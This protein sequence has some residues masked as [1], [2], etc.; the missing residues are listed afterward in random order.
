MSSSGPCR[1]PS[2]LSERKRS[3]RAGARSLGHQS[4]EGLGLPDRE[5]GQNLAVDLDAGALEA[6]DK[7]AVGEPVLAHG[8]VDALDPQG[9]EIPLPQLSPDIG[10]LHRAIDRGVGAGDRILAAA[11]EAF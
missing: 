4:F 2:R 7:S 10:V 6:A 3:A 11:V 9:A 5:I 8:G 1:G